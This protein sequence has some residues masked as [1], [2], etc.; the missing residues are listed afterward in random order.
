MKFTN[1]NM[2]EKGLAPF[3]AVMAALGTGV[4]AAQT[5]AIKGVINSR[6]LTM[7]V[8]VP[9]AALSA[10][11]LG[12]APFMLGRALVT[13]DVAAFRGT[14]TH[15]YSFVCA[16]AIFALVTTAFVYQG[17]Q[18]LAGGLQRS[19]FDATAHRDNRRLYI[20]FRH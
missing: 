3:T 6:P 18:I 8:L 4:V 15:I 1:T 13:G 9:T 20:C 5:S 2:S 16:L 11:V 7:A 12:C 10:F 14:P 17:L 19:K